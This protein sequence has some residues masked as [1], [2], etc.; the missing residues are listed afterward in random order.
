M[1]SALEMFTIHCNVEGES[2]ANLSTRKLKTVTLLILTITFAAS[3]LSTLPNAN[4]AV[5]IISMSPFTG[6]VGTSVSFQANITTVNGSYT[7]LFDNTTILATGNATV[8]HVNTTF[9]VP[10]ATI[11]N[12]SVTIVDVDSSENVTRD[13]EVTTAYYM[14][15]TLPEPPAQMQEGDTPQ[16][17]VTITGAEASKT[18]L[19]NITVVAP[20]KNYSRL[21]NVTTSNDGYSN[22]TFS[23]PEGFAPTGA[24]TNFT[25]TYKA[26]F[27]GTFAA[28]E[29]FIGLTDQ[30]EYHRH[31]DVN[32]RATGYQPSENVTLSVLNSSQ[33][34][35]MTE[36]YT[37][38]DGTVQTTWAVPANMS[39]G[40]YTIKVVSI[41]GTTNKTV[42]DTQ[43]FTVPG[44]DVNVT[45][46]NLAGENT[47][48]ILVRAFED[49]VLVT[50]GTSDPDGTVRGLKLEIGNYSCNASYRDVLI[51]ERQL[52]INDSASVFFECNLTNLRVRIVAVKDGSEVSL[53]E[54]RMNLTSQ[55]DNRTL[56]TDINGT[57][58]AKSLLPNQTYTLDAKRYEFVF[59]TTVIPT[60]LENGDP[61]DW[62]D[63]K[64]FCP[65]YTLRVNV[66]NPNAGN[67]PI[68]G[69]TVRVQESLGGLYYSE[70]TSEGVASFDCPL[71]S[72]SV[73]VHDVNGI[74]LNQTNVVL[75]T[76]TVDLAFSC[77]LYGLDIT[78]RVVDYFGQLITNVNITLR[79]GSWQKSEIPDPNGQ[80]A[81][82]GI[83]GGTMQVTA[84]F[85]GQ[86][87]PLVAATTY[88]DSS[89]T[90]ELRV[91]KYTV[92]AGTLVETNQ[93]LT[94]AI[95]AT[96]VLLVLA[97]EVIRT[98]LRKAQ[99]G[100]ES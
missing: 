72:Y 81:F 38:A 77:K 13:F 60:L 11:G 64:I 25:G 90:I 21:V 15:V 67:Q 40:T 86:T 68:N 32:I 88:V 100:K 47:S 34:T 75:N 46:R 58:T 54:I 23:F 8:N 27:N 37:S 3:F 1:V 73:K 70:A 85:S 57:A 93:L 44:F 26:T 10:Y 35:V 42:P 6:N 39:I 31:D 12:H 59:N 92:L 98:R 56:T 33:I 82:D 9:V 22:E 36:N 50:S 89:R 5:F 61:K 96:L 69:V 29:F 20:D 83:T 30:N 2:L 4:A 66:T 24:S 28:T 71:G 76:T 97:F 79:Q 14:N 17:N 95:M 94:I 80:T 74:M 65:T 7:V 87:D 55:L 49:S 91:E 41:T 84:A 63:L 16:L 43:M 48:G 53:P 99:K 18:Y 51:G 62:Y 19:A 45:T 78:V 52:E